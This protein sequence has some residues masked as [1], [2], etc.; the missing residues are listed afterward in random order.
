MKISALALAQAL[1]AIQW[2]STQKN[3]PASL[4]FTATLETRVQIK[5]VLAELKG[6]VEDE[7]VR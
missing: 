2:A 7:R 1:E 5:M 6:E 3:A 4:A